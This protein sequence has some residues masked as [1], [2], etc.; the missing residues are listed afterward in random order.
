MY[1]TENAGELLKQKRHVLGSRISWMNVGTTVFLLGVTSLLT[2]ISSEMVSAT[3]PLYLLVWLRA[4]LSSRSNGRPLS[5]RICFGAR[6][7]RT[8]SRPVA[9]AQRSC[10]FRLRV[11]GLLQAG[12]PAHWW[13]LDGDLS[14]DLVGPHWQRNPHG[15]ARRDD[16]REQPTSSIGNSVW[17]ASCSGYCGRNARATIGCRY[18]EHRAGAYD[19]I[20]VVSFCVALIGLAVI[21]LF[22]RNPENKTENETGIGETIPSSKSHPAVT[23]RSMVKLLGQAEFRTLVIVG[24]ALSL[25]TV[26]DGLIYLALQQRIKIANGLFPLLYIVTASMFMIFAIPAGRLADRW[27]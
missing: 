12:I 15:T 2:D 17:R 19:A 21:V 13:Q 25:M 11:V 8:D 10:C 24:S 6:D 7:Y 3:L 26:S 18:I 4:P 16:C 20:F 27:G 5:G 14:S 1:Q 9:T 23:L 22:I